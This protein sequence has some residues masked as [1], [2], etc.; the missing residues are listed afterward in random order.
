MF[1]SVMMMLTNEDDDDGNSGDVLVGDDNDD[2]V[3]KRGGTMGKS[4]E[5][6][7]NSTA[8]TA[9]AAAAASVQR[10]NQGMRQF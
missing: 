2:Y 3:D 6:C 10:P 4:F 7:F 5:N 1:F 8:F 9:A